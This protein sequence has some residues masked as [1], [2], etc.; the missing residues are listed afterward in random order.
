MRRL[1]RRLLAPALLTLGLAAC[2]A[3]GP[4]PTPTPT[5]PPATVTAAPVTPTRAAPAA[6]RLADLE[7]YTHPAGAFAVRVPAGWELSDSSQPDELIMLWADPGRNAAVIVNLF[8]ADQEY[9]AGRLA[10]VLGASLERSFGA[11]RDYG[12]SAP[13]PDEAGG[14]R[15]AWGYTRGV[16]GGRE[17]AM[18][19]RSRV[20]QR[21]DTIAI[22]SVL[23]PADMGEELG[24][25]AEAI[26]ASLV[27]RPE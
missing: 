19:G 20:V 22:V 23:L 14:L 5:P 8:E 11:E 9:D 13:E 27:I 10:A 17:E 15:A 6:V 24:E 3:T 1:L 4:P 12:A 21:E 26:L 25:G 16:G 18:A 2:A 7:P